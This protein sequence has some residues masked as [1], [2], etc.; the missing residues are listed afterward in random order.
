MV[1]TASVSVIGCPARRHVGDTVIDSMSQHIVLG[2]VA[3]SLGIAMVAEKN[4]PAWTLR[5]C[6]AA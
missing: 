2:I 5:D 1:F 4:P 3:L 6:V